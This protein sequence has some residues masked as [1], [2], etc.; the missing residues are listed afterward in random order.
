MTAVGCVASLLAC[1][2]CA[3]PAD[4][5][6]VTGAI[7]GTATDD[8][9]TNLAGVTVS[10]QNEATGLRR[11]TVTD[12]D[13][14]YMITGLPVE[15][16]YN[17]RAT[18]T[19]LATLVRE[20]VTVVPN[21]TLIVDFRLAVAAETTVIVTGS[22][23]TRDVAQS[24][25]QQTVPERLVRTLPLAGR[26]FVELASLAAGVTGDPSFPSTQGQIYWSNNVLVDGASHFSKWRS[27]PRTFYSGYSLEAIKEVQVLTNR[28]SAEFGE[29]L[30]TVTSAVS[31]S[32]TNEFRGSALFFLQNDA[33]NA[34]PEFALQNP[35]AGSQQYGFTLG[36]PFVRDRTHFWG[37]YEGRR[38]RNHNIVVSPAAQG[39]IVPND[40]DEHLA[41][42]RVDHQRGERHLLMARYNGQRF[43][44]HNEPGGLSLPGTGTAITNDVHT[45]LLTD[46]SQI[47]RLVLNE[48][49]IQFA[50]YVD[51][52]RDLQPTVFVS[53][54]GYSVE[55][56]TLGPPGFGADPEDTWEGADTVLYARGPHTLKLG[57]GFKH[58]RAHNPFLTYGRGAYFFAGAPDASSRPFLFT[59]ALPPT[60]AAAFADPRS[61]SAFTFVQDDW[62]IRPRLTINL[63]IRYDIED[64]S[65]V[66]NFD[67]PTDANNIQPRVGAAW[68]LTGSG[69]TLLRGGAGLYTQQH[70]LYYINRV[71]LEGVDG[72]ATISLTPDSPLFP[73][74]PNILPGLGAG[75]SMPPRDIQTVDRQFRNPY[76]VQA[77]IG[78]EHLLRDGLVV[79]TDYVFL[80]GRDLMSLVDVNAPASNVKPAQRSVAAAD[81]TR[82]TPPTPNGYRKVIALGNL[83]RST[84]RAL[85]IKAERSIGRLQTTASYTLSRAEDKD[86]YQLPEDSRNLAAEW[87][88]AN[89]DIRHNL[90]VGFSWELPAS[91]GSLSGWSLA[92]I[93]TFRSSRPYDVTWGDDRNGTTQN[94]A[95]PGGRN[96][97]ETDAFSNLDLALARRFSW[98]S[99]TIEAR[100]EAFNLLNTTND[101]EFVGALLSPLY[102]RPVSAFPNRRIQLAIVV[103]F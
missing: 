28:F 102:A 1:L 94:D 47:S 90:A 68:D 85:Q 81:A 55:G 8:R 29:A 88:R 27:A 46:T 59:Q 6:R 42:F 3:A 19:G 24:T 15:G 79:A 60:E 20:R 18:L 14:R 17:I 16:E 67:A 98:R 96:T 86:N 10:V 99:R 66:R 9:G 26:G 5:Q 41:F 45:A 32:G 40:E 91:H 82:P 13:G 39:A 61:V 4:A 97:G 69:R 31:K 48:V 33:L 22:S 11:G 51:L 76:S 64:V 2:A 100:A 77:T 44:R 57:G 83:G 58:V 36:G 62:R 78:F 49:R 89:T 30:A 21:E 87:A 23:P 56:G 35:P 75:I 37:S 63:G 34:T 95:R 80:N 54:A 103:R 52:R 93:G 92:G 101:N 72:V 12:A 50:R 70:L 84:Y 25:V 74:F 7:A 65:E 71:Q 43:R 53:R 73:V 38:T